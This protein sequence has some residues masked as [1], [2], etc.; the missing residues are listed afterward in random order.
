MVM[1]RKLE[2]FPL[3]FGDS[4]V[5]IVGNDRSDCTVHLDQ[6][7]PRLLLQSQLPRGSCASTETPASPASVNPTRTI[8]SDRRG[9]ASLVIESDCHP[10]LVPEPTAEFSKTSSR[11]ADGDAL[12]DLVGL[13][14]LT[15]SV[16]DCRY[17][18]C[19]EPGHIGPP[20]LGRPGAPETSASRRTNGAS[21]LT[22]PAGALIGDR[23]SRPRPSTPGQLASASSSERVGGNR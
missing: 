21:T 18:E 3:S 6:Q 11:S 20:L 17:S 8:K 10:N 1:I 5:D 13:G 2:P 22:G 12:V 15:G 4:V 14:G 16:V 9:C 7:N 23:R 19:P